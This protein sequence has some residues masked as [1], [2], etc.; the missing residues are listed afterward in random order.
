MHGNYEAFASGSDRI[1]DGR[2]FRDS[3]TAGYGI[4]FSMGIFEPG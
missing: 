4:I 2:G 1:D 3:G